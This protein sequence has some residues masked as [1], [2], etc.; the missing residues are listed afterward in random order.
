MRVRALILADAVSVDAE[1]K[2]FV[3]GGG[4]TRLYAHS[5]PW[6]HPQLA[7]W[8]SIER[9]EEPLGSDHD[10]RIR[11]LTPEGSPL[12]PETSAHFRW[13]R[14]QGAPEQLPLLMN[15]ASSYVG[16]S[17]PEPGVYSIQ[18]LVDGDELGRLPFEVLRAST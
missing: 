16:V 15:F 11:F 1:G 2:T 9:D 18:L 13:A 4:I 8:A 14:P 5:F 17:F 3:H 12:G 7:L 10:V 6:T